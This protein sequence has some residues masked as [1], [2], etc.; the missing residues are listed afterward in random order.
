MQL[1]LDNNTGK[2]ALVLNADYTCLNL[3]DVR[4]G[5]ENYIK[6]MFRPDAGLIA[7]DFY[8]Q[9]VLSCGGRHIPIPSVLVT[10]AYKRPK[11]RKVPYSRKNVFLRDNATCMYCGLEDQTR[12][13]LTIDHVIPR[14]IWKRQTHDKSPTGWHN[15]VTA[16]RKCNVFKSNRTPSEAGMRLLIEPF[17]PNP[18]N[19]VLGFSPWMKIQK[20]WIPYFPKNYKNLL[21]KVQTLV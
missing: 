4:N 12:R 20:S 5:L 21:D 14:A 6:N 18:H 15:S 17:E 7:I 2:K 9:K 1:I 13:E 8:D 10:P 19:H 16:C 11:G 3:T